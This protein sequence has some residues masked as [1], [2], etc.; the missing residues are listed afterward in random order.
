MAKMAFDSEIMHY[1]YFII[2]LGYFRT[3]NVQTCW[4]VC[5]NEELYILI[6]VYLFNQLKY[7]AFKI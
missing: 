6:R 4:L 7:V 1:F 5:F 3:Q 2:S